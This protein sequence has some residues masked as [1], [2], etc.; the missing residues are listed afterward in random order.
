MAN[1]LFSLAENRQARRLMLFVAFG[2]A[3]APSIAAGDPI[4]YPANGQSPAQQENDSYHCYRW[5]MD[6][7]GF[8]PSKGVV[9]APPHS[10]ALRGAAGGAALGAAGGAI[11]G[12][13]GQGAAIGAGVGAIVGGA[14]RRAQ[15]HAQASAIAAGRASYNRAY[16]VCMSGR[17]Y[18]VG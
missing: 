2:A 18:R 14:R 12:N 9:M 13:A 17:G 3:M 7:S 6:Q 11:A 15:H 10:N 4:V 16:G 8:D 5:A 1:L